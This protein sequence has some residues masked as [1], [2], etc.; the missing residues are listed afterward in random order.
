MQESHGR[1]LLIVR[2]PQ[3]GSISVLDA[4]C[5]HMGA[6]LVEGD[7]EDVHGRVCVV[8]PAHRY[9]IDIETGKKVDTDLCGN[10][11]AST[12]QKQ[13]VY[14]VACDDE[15]IW[16]DMPDVTTVLQPLPSDYYNQARVP[17]M[18]KRRT[19]GYQSENSRNYGLFGAAPGGLRGPEPLQPY[20]G[21]KGWMPETDTDTSFD[22][23]SQSFAAEEPPLVLS[24]GSTE[25]ND[26]RD[27]DP[28]ESEA[29]VNVTNVP[30]F[31]SGKID[32]PAVKNDLPRI[33]RRKAA[34][35]AIL[36][37]GYRPPMSNEISMQS[38]DKTN[39]I[40]KNNSDSNQLTG[41]GVVRQRT[42]FEAWGVQT[43]SRTDSRPAEI[44]A[45][46]MQ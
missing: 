3:N 6:A 20:A 7:I 24:Q 17:S 38:Y 13:R 31:G 8:C 30:G 12:D 29:S 19:Y 14:K 27:A 46:D 16:V 39:F 23:T 26:M 11:C 2:H 10:M 28:N 42:L 21:V 25:D 33:A 1:K 18:E 44:E 35:A 41:N 45:M 37:R 15:F 4:H 43:D 9:K 36:S 22:S 34:T 32:F 5:F 40:A